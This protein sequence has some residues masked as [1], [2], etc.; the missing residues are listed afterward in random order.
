MSRCGCNDGRLMWIY[1]NG[2][3]ELSLTIILTTSITLMG[4]MT[5]TEVVWKPNPY[6]GA[7]VLMPWKPAE[8]G[9]DPRGLRHTKCLHLAWHN[10]THG[11]SK[12]EKRE[13]T[14]CYI[15]RVLLWPNFTAN[16]LQRKEVVSHD[17]LLNLCFIFYP[18]ILNPAHIII[19]S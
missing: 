2:W 11:C 3:W 5:I 17:E 4:L 14:P 18:V 16:V 8:A 6:S 12:S 10:P 13:G 9:R 15:H 7:D 1:L 19:C